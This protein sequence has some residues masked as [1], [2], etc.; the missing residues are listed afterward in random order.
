MKKKKNLFR[1]FTKKEE[2]EHLRFSY[3]T[4]QY[5]GQSTDQLM[6]TAMS[7][8]LPMSSFFNDKSLRNALNLDDTKAKSLRSTF[9]LDGRKASRPA[10]KME[11]KQTGHFRQLWTQGNTVNMAEKGRAATTSDGTDGD[12][13]DSNKDPEGDPPDRTAVKTSN[14]TNSDEDD[15]DGDPEGD[16]PDRTNRHPRWNERF[17]SPE[18]RG[19]P[20]KSEFYHTYYK[21]GASEDQSR[22]NRTW[23]KHRDILARFDVSE[24]DAKPYYDQGYTNGYDD[25][26]GDCFEGIQR[27]MYPMMPGGYDYDDDD[28]DDDDDDNND[29]QPPEP[30]GHDAHYAYDHHGDY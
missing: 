5:E 29:A 2:E 13:D 15:S 24:K 4:N 21:T 3:K 8:D 9:D 16:P 22:Y 7:R 14:G 30:P 26:F 25:G 28:D 17:P 18:E 19:D 27:D 12:E 1:K 23:E 6:K 11:D 20:H 10:C